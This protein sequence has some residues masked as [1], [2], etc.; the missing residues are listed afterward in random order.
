M[1]IDYQTQEEQTEKTASSLPDEYYKEYQKLS[2][3]LRRDA[4]PGKERAE[5]LEGLLIADSHGIHFLIR[6]RYALAAHSRKILDRF[7]YAK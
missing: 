3:K 2:S 4:L 1:T 7:L 6:D 5:A